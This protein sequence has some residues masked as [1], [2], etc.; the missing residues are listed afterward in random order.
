MNGGEPNPRSPN[1]PLFMAFWS[2]LDGIW[3]LLK[4]SWGLLEQSI[5][6]ENVV[7]TLDLQ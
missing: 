3:G 5:S 2:P 6:S 7:E 1:V 4:R